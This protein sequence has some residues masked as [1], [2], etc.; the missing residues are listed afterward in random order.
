M[1][2][3]IAY[4][5]ESTFHIEPADLELYAPGTGH[6]RVV[7]CLSLNLNRRAG[8]WTIRLQM[9]TGQ[10]SGRLDRAYAAL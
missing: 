9:V 4:D 7:P 3:T 1:S 8:R 5:I 2:A 10:D 6:R